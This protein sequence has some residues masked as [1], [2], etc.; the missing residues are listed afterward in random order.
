MNG[1]ILVASALV[2]V[3]AFLMIAFVAPVNAEKA[4][5]TQL[6]YDG[7]AVTALIPNGGNVVWKALPDNAQSYPFDP[8][9]VFVDE[10]TGMPHAQMPVIGSVPG[11]PEYTGGRWQLFLV[12]GTV[13]AD[14]DIMSVEE[15]MESG[16]EI[17]ETQMYFSCPVV[18]S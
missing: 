7:G 17:E 13:A 4:Q 9:Y 14:D 12:M 2:G 11:D 15:L 3:L 5:R 18:S 8:I 6:Y 10:N 16:L 1:K